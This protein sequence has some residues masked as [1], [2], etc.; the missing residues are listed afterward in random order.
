MRLLRNRLIPRALLGIMGFLT[1]IL[2][3]GSMQDL[4]ANGLSVNAFLML[5]LTLPLALLSFF[6]AM[7][8]ADIGMDR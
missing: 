3:V 6:A 7:G 5:L 8:I 2:A 4:I 1:L